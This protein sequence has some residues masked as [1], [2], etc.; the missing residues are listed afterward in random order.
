M[1]CAFCL[2]VC[3]H[4]LLL[5]R[6]HFYACNNN[7]SVAG[8]L[9]SFAGRAKSAMHKGC[10][11]CRALERTFRKFGL[12]MGIRASSFSWYVPLVTCAHVSQHVC[13]SQ[14][15]SAQ[16]RLR[17]SGRGLLRRQAHARSTTSCPPRC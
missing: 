11:Q 1:R 9:M 16:Q 14:K 7:T 13:F 2:T 3:D 6:Q 10:I 5:L 8:L 4:Y 17:G 15:R 12:W